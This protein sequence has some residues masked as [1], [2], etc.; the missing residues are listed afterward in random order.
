[1][2]LAVPGVS[3]VLAGNATPHASVAIQSGGSEA[4]TI[5]VRSTAGQVIE[6]FRG[7]R[8]SVSPDGRTLCRLRRK[9][10]EPIAAGAVPPGAL[11]PLRD[12]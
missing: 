7:W 1:M 6:Q 8:A 4:D 11:R 10:A 9:R 2:V 12:R 3:L 5:V